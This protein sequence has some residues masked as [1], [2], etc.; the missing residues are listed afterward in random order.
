MGYF[1]QSFWG[2]RGAE[3][4]LIAD[5]VLDYVQIPSASIGTT[6]YTGYTGFN[7]KT[8]KLQPWDPA[9]AWSADDMTIDSRHQKPGTPKSAALSQKTINALFCDGHAATVGAREAFNAIRNPGSDST[10]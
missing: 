6:N 2:R 3:R 4:L 7:T 8:V 1:K 9:P 10:K 5:S